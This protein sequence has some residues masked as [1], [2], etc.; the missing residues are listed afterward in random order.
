MLLD[1][2][3]RS[4]L[5]LAFKNKTAVLTCSLINAIPAPWRCRI[6][7]LNWKSVKMIGRAQKSPKNHS[8]CS[9]DLKIS[10]SIHETLV[11]IKESL[12]SLWRRVYQEF[13][14]MTIYE[15]K[16]INISRKIRWLYI[17][18]WVSDTVFFLLF[19]IINQHNTNP[20]SVPILKN[21][22]WNIQASSWSRISLAQKDRMVERYHGNVR[23][24]AKW[25]DVYPHGSFL[26]LFLDYIKH[27]LIESNGTL[28]FPCPTAG[29]SIV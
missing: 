18:T 9:K 28:K 3:K 7:W 12:A 15:Q 27:R 23:K 24:P 5:V 22:F 8:L 25:Q 21:C 13:S 29:Q 1:N 2:K 19:N 26:L 4:N 10:C 11:L 6:H 20:H 17:T 16:E 14:L